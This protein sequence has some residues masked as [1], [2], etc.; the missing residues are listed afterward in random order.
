MAK[1][2]STQI[3]MPTG[4]GVLRKIVGLAVLIALLVIVVKHPSDAAAAA[5]RAA[6]FVG[7]VIDG[8]WSFVQQLG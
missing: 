4:G 6:G 3:P 1:R 7:S 5:T 8:L 2:G